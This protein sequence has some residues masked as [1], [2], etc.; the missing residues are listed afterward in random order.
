[1]SQRISRRCEGLNFSQATVDS[2]VATAYFSI[3]STRHV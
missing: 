1:M 3:V 2:R